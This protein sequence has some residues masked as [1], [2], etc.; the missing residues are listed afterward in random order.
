MTLVLSSIFPNLLEHGHPPVLSSLTIGDKS[1]IISVKM[2]EDG[3]SSRLP[4]LA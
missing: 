4:P 1:L 3:K 2:W